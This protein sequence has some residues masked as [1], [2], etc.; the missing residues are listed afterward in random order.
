MAIA[1]S[2]SKTLRN[3]PIEKWGV[4]LSALLT[5]LMGVINL[6]SSVQPAFRDRL[7]LIETV[8][9][10]TIRH[11]SRMTAALA[12]FALIMLASSLARRKRVAWIVT[13]VLLIITFVTHMTKG[14]DFEDSFLSLGLF[15]L[16]ILLRNSFHAKSDPPSIRQGLVTLFAAFTFTLAYGTIG[17]Y[18]LDRHFRISYNWIEAIRQ[19]TVMFTAF[20][21]PGLE[22]L[23]GFGRYFAGSIYVIGLGT[24]GFAILMLLRP[25][26]VRQPATPE[27]RSHAAELVHKH[28]HTSLARATLF[29]DKSYFSN[30]QDTVIAYVAY[31]RG[32]LTLGD[33]IGPPGQIAESIKRFR[34]FCLSK[35]WTPAFASVLPDY[36]ECY[37]EADFDTICIGYEA[38]VPLDTFT[39]QGSQNKDVR[40]A[41]NR[42]ERNGYCVEVHSPP[43]DDSLIYALHEISN[44][45]LT[46]RKGGEMHFSVGWF[47]EAYIR[48]GPVA[49]V[50]NADKRPVAFANLV[51]EYQKSE[52]TIDLMRHYPHPENGTMEFMFARMLQWAKDQGCATFSLGLSPIVGIGQKPDDPRVERALR[53]LSEYV[54]RFYNFKGLHNFKEKFHPRW[55]PRYLAYPSPAS[56]PLVLNTLLQAQSGSNYLYNFLRK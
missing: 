33:P 46:E 27:E 23:T 8:V 42:M 20:Y 53:T 47:D 56:L 32:A 52:L 43:L 28:G 6:T 17:F 54:S 3:L 40:N 39:L 1:Q 44:A 50:Y 29:D 51:P 19:T 25:V 49:V 55:E 16:L 14:L 22:P 4:W 31:G 13:L 5:F 45:W 18:L 34:S 36:L 9:P 7:A 41:V 10:L 35:D 48:S 12:G 30:P 24:I 11:G 26:L 38:I 37:R 15:L 21:D 2:A